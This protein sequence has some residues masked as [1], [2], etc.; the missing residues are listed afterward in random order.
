M[1]PFLVDDVS[2][3]KRIH[4]RSVKNQGYQPPTNR[5]MVTNLNPDTTIVLFFLATKLGSLWYTSRYI[6]TPIPMELRG[7]IQI[8]TILLMEEILHRIDSLPHN[9]QGSIKP[10]GGWPSDFWLP[11]T[12]SIPLVR[13]FFEPSKKTQ[14]IVTTQRRDFMFSPPNLEK[15]WFPIWTTPRKIN[16]WNIIMKVWF[17]SFSFLFMDAL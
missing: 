5:T 6:Q 17:R 12:V 8:S 11:S 16:G 7:E 13:Q 10:P 1:Q 14:T 3:M 15:N 4:Q 2:G 9:W